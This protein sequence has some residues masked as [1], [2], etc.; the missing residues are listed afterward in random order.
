MLGIA[1]TRQKQKVKYYRISFT[2]GIEN[3]PIGPLIEAENRI[4]V[5]RSWGEGEMRRCCLKSTK[6]QFWKNS[7]DLL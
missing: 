5:T 4:V 7:G 6:F 2:C 1:E 3:S